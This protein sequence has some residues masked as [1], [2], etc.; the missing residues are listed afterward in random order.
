MNK[1]ASSNKW[2]YIALWI[3][4]IVGSL[5]VLPYAFE[6]GLSNAAVSFSLVILATVIQAAILF[7][8]ACWLSYFLVPRTDLSP[9]ATKGFLKRIVYPGVIGGVAV[10]LVL[11]GLSKLFFAGSVFAGAHPTAW[12]GFLASIYGGVNEEVLLRLFFFTLLYFLFR[13]VF[14]VAKRKRLLFLWITNL[15]IAVL[16]GAAHLPAAFKL[17]SINSFEVTRILLLNGVASCVFG[18]LY[19]SRGLFAAMAAHF[20]TDWMIHVFFTL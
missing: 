5:S 4:C 8:G 18:W 10:G 15:I 9:F 6:L 3:A 19:F 7:G 13:K 14:P 20:V 16:F 17:A 1:T 2:I 11:L 12:K